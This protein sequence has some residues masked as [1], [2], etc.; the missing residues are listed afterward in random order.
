MVKS[1]SLVCLCFARIFAVIQ[2]IQATLLKTSFN[3]CLLCLSKA[4]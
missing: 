3:K 4:I 2:L 1:F